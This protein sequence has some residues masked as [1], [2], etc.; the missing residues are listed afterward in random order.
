M[1]EHIAL[2]TPNIYHLA[3]NRRKSAKQKYFYVY[4]HFI[5]SVTDFYFSI[6]RVLLLASSLR[7]CTCVYL[8]MTVNPTFF[9]FIFQ[10]NILFH[11]NISIDFTSS[12][13]LVTC[14][15]T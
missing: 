4:V 9:W 14:H 6:V 2:K 10:P 7:L 11:A 8:I 1:T 13:Q 15:F 5:D 3:F 12:E